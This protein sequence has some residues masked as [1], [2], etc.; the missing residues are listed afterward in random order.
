MAVSKRPCLTF[1]AAMSFFYAKISLVPSIVPHSTFNLTPA[2][3]IPMHN[4]TT[5][6]TLRPLTY[7]LL[8][9]NSSKRSAP[10]QAAVIK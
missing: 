3:H 5:I 6:H 4:A 2:T 9:Q 1:T 10:K 7:E 8:F